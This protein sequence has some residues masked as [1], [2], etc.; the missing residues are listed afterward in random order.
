MREVIDQLDTIEQKSDAMTL[1]FQ[2]WSPG[3]K[4]AD[5]AGVAV[6]MVQQG[7]KPE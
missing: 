5:T 6:A 4:L 2:L 1:A 7:A 3:E